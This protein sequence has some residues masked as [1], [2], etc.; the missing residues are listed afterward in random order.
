MRLITDF[1]KA[2]STATVNDGDGID[3]CVGP[4][5]NKQ[6]TVKNFLN[7]YEIEVKYKRL[8]YIGLEKLEYND[9]IF[10]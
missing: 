6:I 10:T 5:K 7:P 4:A 9:I 3:A 2:V 8:L 1:L